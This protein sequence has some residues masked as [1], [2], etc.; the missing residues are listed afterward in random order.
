MLASFGLQDEGEG[1][2]ADDGYDDDDEDEEDDDLLAGPD[3][4]W[5][6]EADNPFVAGGEVLAAAAAA[7]LAKAF[8]EDD[9]GEGV[10]GEGSGSGQ[11]GE[12]SG[13]GQGG[14]GSGSG[15]GGEG[16]GGGQGGEGG[17]REDPFA[18]GDLTAEELDAECQRLAEEVGNLKTQRDV[19]EFMDQIV[20]EDEEQEDA[21]Y[22]T[23]V[24]GAEDHEEALAM[25]KQKRA[26]NRRRL[27]RRLQTEK[28]RA[29]ADEKRSPYNSKLMRE[30]PD[31]GSIVEEICR[32][33]C[34]GACRWR[35]T[36]LMVLEQGGGMKGRHVTFE[37]IRR[38]L[39]AHYGKPISLSSVKRF[40]QARN[41]C[42][43]SS[44]W[45]LRLAQVVCR[46]VGAVQVEHS[47]PTA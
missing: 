21:D 43:R 39:V 26:A 29:A 41:K 25:V 37:V 6:P 45:Y 9:E 22:L 27:K 17:E 46:T 11:W 12:G 31:A 18:H 34:V 28:A 47:C 5:D 8:E 1:K 3:G 10:S 38:A 32:L 19:D 30:F 4:E 7:C 16:S 2:E 13:G 40:C 35:R 23:G 14:E 15:Q 36:G 20:D 42:R 44:S 24:M 33:G